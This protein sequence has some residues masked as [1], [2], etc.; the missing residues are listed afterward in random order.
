MYK[1]RLMTMSLSQA[2]DHMQSCP[3]LQAEWAHLSPQGYCDLAWPC[4]QRVAVV[5]V[6]VYEEEIRNFERAI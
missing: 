6:R 1:R 5:V 4:L 2:T 3:S